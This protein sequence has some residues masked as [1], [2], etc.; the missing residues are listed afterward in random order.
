MEPSALRAL[1]YRCYHA[2]RLGE[3]R[4]CCA[5][6][7]WLLERWV[8]EQIFSALRAVALPAVPPGLPAGAARDRRRRVEAAVQRARRALQE[9]QDSGADASVTTALDQELARAL[10]EQRAL[11]AEPP[12]PRRRAPSTSQIAALGRIAPR[13]EALW[14]A[15]TTSDQD[16][17][18]LVRLAIRRVIVHRTTR[19]HVDVELVWASGVSIRHR[20]LRLRAVQE[21]LRSLRRMGLPQAL[22]ESRLRADGAVCLPPPPRPS[23]PR[24]C[25]QP[26][27]PAQKRHGPAPDLI[28]AV[29]RLIATGTSGREIARRFAVERACRRCRETL[30]QV[31]RHLRRRGIDLPDNVRREAIAESRRRPGSLTALVRQLLEEGVP[32]PD[33]ARRLAEERA[34]RPRVRIG[35]VFNC[36]QRQGIQ[37]PPAVRQETF[38]EW[39]RLTARPGS[40]TARVR[41]L[42]EEG[43]PGPEIARRLAE[44]RAR[45]SRVRIDEVFNCLQRQGIQIPP[46]V[47]QETF[48]EWRRLTARPGA[49]WTPAEL[50]PRLVALRQAGRRWKAIAE[51]LNASGLRR[52]SGKPFTDTGL[53]GMFGRHRRFARFGADQVR[54]YGS[55]VVDRAVVAL[56]AW[57]ATHQVASRADYQAALGTRFSPEALDRARMNL[58]RAG[59]LRVIERLRRSWRWSWC[60]PAVPTPGRALAGRRQ[61]R[62]LAEA[63][64]AILAML[65]QRPTLRRQDRI[66]HLSP[67][68][69]PST[70]D[71]ARRALEAEGLLR[72]LP[73]AGRR[74][75]A[76]WSRV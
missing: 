7:A 8:V 39:R 56:S 31:F 55:L 29:R 14:A 13:L 58:E 54:A 62:R 67:P 36:L 46:A 73:R 52:P 51:H 12:S 23:R 33:I 50:V 66:A 25:R 20:L 24:R 32:G 19:E 65:E 11:E 30:S 42:L 16:R 44:E 71:T 18:R 17:Q 69:L 74:A 5:I 63:R 64:A 72:R 61:P 68:F 1:V 53:M 76:V 38:A 21:R 34:R 37:I 9:A 2:T 59:R 48:A 15:P 22:I 49:A 41:Q 75:P 28:E 6:P 10:A 60:E 26:G 4:F 47:R 43:V 70:L 35:E 57:F 45:R 3:K 40:L 27:G